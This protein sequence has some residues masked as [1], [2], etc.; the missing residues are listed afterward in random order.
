MIAASR[1]WPRLV[2]AAVAAAALT[3]AGQ[4]PWR[5]PWSWWLLMITGLTLVLWLARVPQARAGV[6]QQPVS[7]APVRP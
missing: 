3:F 2:A 6:L 7:A 5:D 1:S 4:L